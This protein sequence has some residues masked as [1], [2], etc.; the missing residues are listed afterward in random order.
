[1]GHILK[2][3]HTKTV[4]HHENKTRTQTGTKTQTL[5]FGV[6][7]TGKTLHG[8]VDLRC[9]TVAGDHASVPSAVAIVSAK[10]R[11]SEPG[12]KPSVCRV[13]HKVTSTD[14]LSAAHAVRVVSI[15]ATIAAAAGSSRSIEPTASILVSM[16]VSLSAH[17][18][19]AARS[20]RALAAGSGCCCDSI[21]CMAAS[22]RARDSTR[23]AGRESST[24]RKRA[25]LPRI[26]RSG[27]P[28]CLSNSSA[29]A[30]S[31]ASSPLGSPPGPSSV[32]L[33]ASKSPIPSSSAASTSGL[34]S[35]SAMAPAVTGDEKR[36][37]S[38][39]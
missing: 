12:A 25:I 35:A 11:P 4:E 38:P 16:V 15:L 29:M 10:L 24:L 1:M 34:W 32:V 8:A 7:G 13:G 20:A 39:P 17:R 2:D 36:S 22:I 5:K 23:A 28:L 30:S 18:D 27:S 6:T 3:S 14:L 33:R 21:V 19:W 37:S 9:T 26:S 31:C